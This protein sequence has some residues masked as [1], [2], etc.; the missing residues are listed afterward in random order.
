MKLK[1][2]SC[3]KEK[4]FESEQLAFDEG[5]DFPPICPV[6]TCGNCPSAPLIFEKL[7][8]KEKKP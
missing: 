1:C 6:T 2:E 5:W 8:E 3:G 7:Q 4:E